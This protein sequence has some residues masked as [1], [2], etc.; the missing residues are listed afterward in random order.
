MVDRGRLDFQNNLR[1]ID[2]RI[3]SNAPKDEVRFLNSS[4]EPGSWDVICQGG[5]ESYDHGAS[6][7]EKLNLS[8]IRFCFLC[9]SFDE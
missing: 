8:A 7:F 3:R 5:K 9:T 1:V 2:P 6:S 4:F